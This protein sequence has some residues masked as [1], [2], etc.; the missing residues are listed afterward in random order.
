MITDVSEVELQRPTF[1]AWLSY[2]FLSPHLSLTSAVPFASS[3]GNCLIKPDYEFITRLFQMKEK[4]WGPSSHFLE[5]ASPQSFS[6]QNSVH[7]FDTM[8]FLK[9]PSSRGP[10]HECDAVGYAG[11]GLQLPATPGTALPHSTFKS[12]LKSPFLL[13]AAF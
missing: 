9:S 6:S 3:S 4:T 7:L 11:S 12:I 5:K 8:K 10:V 1:T 13:V 2:Q